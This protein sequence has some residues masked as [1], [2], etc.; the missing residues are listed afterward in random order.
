MPADV[1]MPRMGQ[2]M[3]TGVILK[4][5]KQP[6]E[7]V[8]R[9][10]PLVEIE[11]DKATVDIESLFSGTVLELVA[12]EGD[13][14]EVGA[15]IARIEERVQSVG[16]GLDQ[17][18]MGMGRSS[19]TPTPE[20]VSFN[21]AARKGPR[22]NASPLAKRLANAYGIDLLALTGSGPGGRIGKADI[23]GWLAQVQPRAVSVSHVITSA[24][25][26]TTQTQTSG[27][28]V[29][30]N[31]MR[32]TAAR[33][34][35]QSKQQAP[36]FYVAMDVEMTRVLQLRE[37]LKARGV[38]VSVN[39]LI[40]KAVALALVQFPNLNATFDG[41]AVVQHADVN[42]AVAVAV[43]DGLLTPVVARCQTLALPDLAAQSRQAAERARA[44]RLNPADLEGGTFTVSNLGMFGVKHFEAIV[45]PPHAAILAVGAV[46][47]IP[48]F[49]AQD[50]IIAAQLMTVTVSADHRVTDGAEV[51]RFL[52]AFKQTLEDGFALVSSF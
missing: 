21:G 13:T 37:S 31:K 14:V 40:L 35:V 6:G 22:A 10:D 38:A 18:G 42:L 50:R 34:M 44:G 52:A 30:L 36:H 7:A 11:T 12:Q 19:P 16:A 25:P 1:T 45:N 20:A 9:G 3:E 5:L 48:V 26:V 15:L 47:R 32:Q 2:S 41:D 24:A 29:P 49:D 51:A 8:Q 28:R 43:E 27:K 4:W 46:Q 17:P 23:D 33:R 39:D